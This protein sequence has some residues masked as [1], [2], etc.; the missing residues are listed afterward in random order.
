MPVIGSLLYKFGQ[1]PVF[2]GRGDAG[3]VLK[4]AEKALSKGASRDRVPRGHRQP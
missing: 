3:L 2:R 1:L 4:Q